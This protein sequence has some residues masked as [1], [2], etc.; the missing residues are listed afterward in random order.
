MKIAFPTQ[1][2][3]GMES[4]VFSHFGS[5]P[6]FVIVETET[7]ASE[8]IT[9]K[10]LHHTH[11]QCNPMA[12]LNGVKTDAIAAGGIGRGALMKLNNGGVSVYRAVEGTVSEN[13]ELIAAGKLPKFDPEHTCAGHSGGECA[14]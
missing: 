2:D 6:F 7:R 14:H 8:T 1:N 3:Q 12:A 9:N 10:D 13:L 4:P 5:A 11:G